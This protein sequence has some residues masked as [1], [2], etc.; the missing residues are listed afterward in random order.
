MLAYLINAALAIYLTI[1]QI[2]MAFFLYALSLLYRLFGKEP[3]ATGSKPVTSPSMP[4]LP[5]GA[6]PTTGPNWAEIV[7]ALIFWAVFL[8]ILF[9]A[10]RQYLRQHQ[11]ILEKLRALPGWVFLAQV[12]GW[13]QNLLAR[14]QS[15]VAGIVAAGRERMLQLTNRRGFRAGFI[16]LRKLDPR[17]RVY[18]FY[19]ALIRRGGEKGLP[20]SISQT[21]DEYA[22]ELQAALPTA[23]EDIHSLTQ[24]FVDARYS[25]QPVQPEQLQSVESACGRLRKA[26]RGKLGKQ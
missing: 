1:G 25:R 12:W 4:D 14:A 20:R 22:A 26:L 21:P 24:A 23:D 7:K 16:N 6:T 5:I 11:G 3:P 18:F 19:L 9:F 17:Q 15:G 8:G 2:I 10:A 13:L